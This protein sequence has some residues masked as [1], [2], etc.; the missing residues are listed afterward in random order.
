MLS[1]TLRSP[2]L[3]SLLHTIDVDLAEMSRG[4]GCP[5]VVGRCI[6]QHMFASLVAALLVYLKSIV[7]V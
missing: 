3:F 5:F 1:E 4:S 2:Q 7:F 6:V